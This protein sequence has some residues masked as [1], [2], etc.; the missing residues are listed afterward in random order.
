MDQIRFIIIVTDK[1]EESKRKQ[2]IRIVYKMIILYDFVKRF[3]GVSQK[4]LKSCMTCVIFLLLLL[5]VV[6]SNMTHTY[7]V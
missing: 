1:P 4:N 6:Y 7:P 2:N 5:V 3:K